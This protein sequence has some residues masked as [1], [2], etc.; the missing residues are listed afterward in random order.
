MNRPGYP[1]M[2]KHSILGLPYLGRRWC[3]TVAFVRDDFFDEKGSPSH[4]YA[5]GQR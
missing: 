5:P 1:T 4:A 3:D 2:N